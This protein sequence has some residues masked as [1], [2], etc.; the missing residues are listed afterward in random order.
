MEF[1]IVNE[2]KNVFHRFWKFSNS[3]AEKFCKSPELLFRLFL[4]ASARHVQ[5]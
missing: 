1:Q 5:A 4:F 3:A 2:R